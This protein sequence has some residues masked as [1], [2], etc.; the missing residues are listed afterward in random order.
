[1]IALCLVLFAWV[2]PLLM[3]LI[4]DGLPGCM[5]GFMISGFFLIPLSLVFAIFGICNKVERKLNTIAIV[6]GTLPFVLAGISFLFN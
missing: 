3:G 6:L 5:V 1:M 2:F 4:Y